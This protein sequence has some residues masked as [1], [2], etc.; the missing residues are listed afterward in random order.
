MPR[1]VKGSG[2]KKAKK[3][4]VAAPQAVA[5]PAAP[6]AAAPEVAATPAPDESSWRPLGSVD[7]DSLAGEALKAYA[8]RAGLREADIDFLTEDR[9]RQN[10]KLAIAN[11]FELLSE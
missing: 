11:H 9:L 10:V 2:P 5:A 1:G 4:P 3:A 8:R 6:P 7:V